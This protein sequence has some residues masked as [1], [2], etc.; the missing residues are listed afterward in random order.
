MDFK[1]I[2][3]D[4]G[5]CIYFSGALLSAIHGAIVV[6]TIYQDGGSYTTFRA[7]SSTQREETYSMVTANRFWSEIFGV[8]FQISDGCISLSFLSLL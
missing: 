1:S 5:C 2:S 4:D 6:N 7:F 8:A 3:Y